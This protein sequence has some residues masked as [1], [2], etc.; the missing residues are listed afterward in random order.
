VAA[1]VKSAHTA[2]QIITVV[3]V[4]ATDQPSALA[5]GLAVVPEALGACAGRPE[6]DHQLVMA[7]T[8]A[9]VIPGR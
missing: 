4:E 5:A 2:G 3:V 8:S 9:S 6:R 7:W 1:G